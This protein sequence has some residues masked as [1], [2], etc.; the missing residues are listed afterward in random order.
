MKTD[1]EKR[2]CLMRRKGSALWPVSQADEE[3]LQELSNGDIEVTFKNRRSN[4]QLRAYWVYLAEV[5]AAT[6]AY[7][8]A[9]KLHEALKFAMGYVTTIILFD[10]T[11]QT[12]ADSV[13]LSKMDG[14]EFTGFYRRAE[15]LIA[16]RF[17]FD[18]KAM[19]RAA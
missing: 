17:G 15:R 14:A 8:T 16:E 1:R 2:I 9:E 13:A 5:V 18:A 19:R 4:E 3:I 7:P 11:V 6:E 12:I 10:G